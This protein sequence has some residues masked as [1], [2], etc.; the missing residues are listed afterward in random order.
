MQG[1]KVHIL[2]V[3]NMKII[4][5]EIINKDV[6]KWRTSL[7]IDLISNREKQE[8]CDLFRPNQWKERNEI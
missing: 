5:L 1:R 2:L 8:K 7:G 3:I 4:S 6:N